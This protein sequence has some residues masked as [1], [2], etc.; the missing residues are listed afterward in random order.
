[1]REYCIANGL[2]HASADELLAELLEQPQPPKRHIDYL[3]AFITAWES[4]V[5]VQALL[6]QQEASLKDG[7]CMAVRN[8]I[9]A[10]DEFIQDDCE[11]I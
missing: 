11:I 3:K 9:I 8:G 6:N 10:H 2:E 7:L 1:M 4:A 5:T